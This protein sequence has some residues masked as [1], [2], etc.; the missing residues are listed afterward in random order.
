MIVKLADFKKGKTPMRY[1]WSA[2]FI[3]LILSGCS[4]NTNKNPQNFSLVQGSRIP[5]EKA[6][7]IM[8][9]RK[10]RWVGFL[11]KIPIFCNSSRIA[12]VPVRKCLALTLEPGHYSFHTGE[13]TPAI[14]ITGKAGQEYFLEIYSPFSWW[15]TKFELRQIENKKGMAESGKYSKIELTYR[16]KQQTARIEKKSSPPKGPVS[17][18]IQ[19]EKGLNPQKPG[20]FSRHPLLRY[21]GILFV[22]S[23]ILLYA[24]IRIYVKLQGPFSDMVEMVTLSILFVLAVFAVG[25]IFPFYTHQWIPHP[26]FLYYFLF[27]LIIGIGIS[28]MIFLLPDEEWG[29]FFGGIFVFFL[30]SFYVGF[31]PLKLLLK[32]YP[33]GA[34]WF[35][36]L[37]WW[38]A[39]GMVFFGFFLVGL[40]IIML[41]KLEGLQDYSGGDET[42]T[43]GYWATLGGKF[44][45]NATKR[46]TGE[47]M[48]PISS[49]IKFLFLNGI[50]IGITIYFYLSATLTFQ[51]GILIYTGLLILTNV[52][53]FIVERFRS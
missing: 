34:E 5:S 21:F 33:E 52:L 49:F 3:F 51:W 9:Y 11:I 20:F 22:V 53:L 27:S 42:A 41:N 12:K 4:E 50:L 19:E 43:T 47:W 30:L 2:C 14:K 37:P 15:D 10:S 39:L 13:G 38:K 8:I 29:P 26:I 6:L 45:M 46:E 25:S 35:L 48:P 1:F 16:Q 23:L 32:G 36:S 17:P 24:A 7:K 44:Y 31:V 40:N 18:F 28:F